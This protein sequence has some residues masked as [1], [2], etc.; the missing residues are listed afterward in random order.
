M[1]TLNYGHNTT[2]TEI[3]GGEY[4]GITVF[5]DNI[6]TNTFANYYETS[7]ININRF[8]DYKMCSLAK[9]ADVRYLCIY[10][11][12]LLDY[13]FDGRLQRLLS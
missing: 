9:I 1:K 4:L 3:S 11:G 8:C 6:H 5:S 7:V 12:K 13:E 2:T 10:V